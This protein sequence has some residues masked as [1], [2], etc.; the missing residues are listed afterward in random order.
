MYDD[1]DYVLKRMLKMRRRKERGG[2]TEE[3]EEENEEEEEENYKSDGNGVLMDV[4]LWK[5]GIR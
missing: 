4:D 2:E 3:G 1:G 5:D